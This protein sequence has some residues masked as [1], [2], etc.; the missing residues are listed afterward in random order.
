MT[1]EEDLNS[2]S[3]SVAKGGDDVNISDSKNNIMSKAGDDTKDGKGT[4]TRTRGDL[5][6][7]SAAAAAEPLHGMSVV[8]L[9]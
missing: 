6:S 3:K 5:T 4:G 8:L 2:I 1:L 9:T 7:S